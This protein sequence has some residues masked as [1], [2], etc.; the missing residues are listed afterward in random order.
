MAVG[1]LLPSTTLALCLVA[2]DDL[3]ADGE[4]DFGEEV[5]DLGFLRLCFFGGLATSEVEMPL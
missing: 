4:L 5:V 3:S 1:E 2:R